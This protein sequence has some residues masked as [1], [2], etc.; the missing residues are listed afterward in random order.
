MGNK[1]V[2]IPKVSVGSNSG[3]DLSLNVMD[4]FQ[5]SVLC[6]RKGTLDEQIHAKNLA[7]RVLLSQDECTDIALTTREGRLSWNHLK[8][9][10][11]EF[12][13]STAEMNF[14]KDQVKRLDAAKEITN[15][16]LGLCLKIQ[17][18][19]LERSKVYSKV[20]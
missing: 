19:K 18:A 11:R 10:S 12:H 8:D 2:G 5:V 16:M 4:R 15:E 9:F 6:P 14:L 20:A 17:E 3:A 1:K 7:Q 13:F